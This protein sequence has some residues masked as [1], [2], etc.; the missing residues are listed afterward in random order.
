MQT[1]TPAECVTI[2]ERVA[3]GRSSCEIAEELKRSL[4]TIHK[5]RQSDW[6][7]KVRKYERHH[8]LSGAKAK[9]AQRPHQEWDMDAQ[10]ATTIAGLGKVSFI[11][12]FH[13]LPT[14]ASLGLP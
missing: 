8:D 1:T 4:S 5:W 3:S 10:G 11:T 12:G 6:K 13:P 7:K 9:P 14:G 2:A